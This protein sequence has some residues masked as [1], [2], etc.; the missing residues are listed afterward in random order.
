MT[1]RE[2]L[3]KVFDLIP[4]IKSKDELLEDEFLKFVADHK[5]TDARSLPAIKAFFKAYVTSDLTRYIV[6][7]GAFTELATNPVF[8]MRDLRSV[9]APYRKLVPEYVKDYVSLNQFTV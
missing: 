6:D 4:H 3:E 7:E 5:P 2:I 9:P 8:S 1:L